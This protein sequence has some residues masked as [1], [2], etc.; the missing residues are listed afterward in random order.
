M[1]GY[2]HSIPRPQDPGQGSA[3]AP[4]GTARAHEPGSGPGRVAGWQLP[5]C[6]ADWQLRLE[7]RL[8]EYVARG[9]IH[10]VRLLETIVLAEVTAA[11]ENALRLNT[12]RVD[13]VRHLFCRIERRPLVSMIEPAL[14]SHRLC[15]HCIHD[16]RGAFMASLTIRNLPEETHRALRIRAAQHGRST[17]AEIRAILEDTVRPAGR[18]K[19]GSLIHQIAQEVG[20]MDDLEIR[21]D[22]SEIIGANLK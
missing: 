19:I 2:P 18:L 21:R 16:S 8:R 12:I 13:A 14:S 6:F 9:Q 17:E 11:V 7:A 3:A 5:E 15:Y 22:R 20:G 4:Y 1:Y 10:V